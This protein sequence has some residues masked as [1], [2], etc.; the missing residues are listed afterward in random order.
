MFRV[1]GEL[2]IP[3]IMKTGY[4]GSSLSSVFLKFENLQK[5]ENMHMNPLNCLK[6]ILSECLGHGPLWNSSEDLQS[7]IVFSAV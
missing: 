4:S 7:Q 5:S 3:F 2:S 6:R 1:F